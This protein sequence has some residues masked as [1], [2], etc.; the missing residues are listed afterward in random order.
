ME[1]APSKESCTHRFMV[2]KGRA[3]MRRLVVVG[4]IANTCGNGQLIIAPNSRSDVH[5]LMP[6]AH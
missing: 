6:H 5:E 2:S 3:H 1:G 4:R